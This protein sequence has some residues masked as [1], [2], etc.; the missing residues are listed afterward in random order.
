MRESVSGK[1]YKRVRGGRGLGDA[2]Y[3][4][5][6]ID[7][8]IDLGT[9]VTVLTDYPELYQGYGALTRPFERIK[10]DICA[11]Y[12]GHKDRVGTT[13]WQDVCSASGAPLDLALKFKWRV[14][15][16]KM[17]SGLRAQAN[18]RP[19]V[20]V[21]GG[22]TPMGRADGFGIE[23]M[24]TAEA[25]ATVLDELRGCLLVQVG[26]AVQLYPIKSEIDL[27]GSTTVTDLIDLGASCDGIV[28]QCSFAVP[29]AEAF[30]KPLLAVWG[31][32]IP[33]SR[34][35]FVR[36]TTP[37]KILGG[38]KD[39]FVVDNWGERM[40]RWTASDFA[41]EVFAA[42]GLIKPERRQAA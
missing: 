27:N 32:R 18:G 15:N 13:Q 14:T 5:A 9:H 38:M 7:H 34:E 23:L 42:R 25:F 37:L 19:I 20:L 3:V 11:H 4:R 8:V 39:R 6:I 40:L 21:H 17:I 2:I 26:K 33:E 29:L 30:D 22:R 41:D 12:V 35:R 1:I 10:V 24:P 36:Q 31:S 16:H 28:A